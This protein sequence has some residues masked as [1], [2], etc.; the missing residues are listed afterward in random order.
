MIRNREHMRSIVNFDN[1]TFGKISPM[2]LDAFMEFNNKLYIFIETKYLDAKM[3]F[4]QE[5]ALERLCD[6]CYDSGKQSFVFVTS[7][8]DNDEIDLGNSTVTKYRWEKQWHIPKHEVTLHD[9][10]LKLKGKYT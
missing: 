10:V 5:L 6:M 3:P 1:M 4:G 2:D 9:A 7:H 8:N